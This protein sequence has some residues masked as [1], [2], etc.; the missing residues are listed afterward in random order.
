MQFDFLLELF[1][2]NLSIEIRPEVT[3]VSCP[4]WKERRKRKGTQGRERENNI[5]L[6]QVCG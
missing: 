2:F 5:I 6:G 4:L 3:E 1:I